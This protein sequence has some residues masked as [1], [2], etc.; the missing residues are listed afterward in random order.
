[1]FSSICKGNDFHIC[2]QISDLKQ[3]YILV[4]EDKLGGLNDKGQ[5]KSIQYLTGLKRPN[6]RTCL[7]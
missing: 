2:G 7:Y 3:A 4:Y 6:K 5:I 1:M